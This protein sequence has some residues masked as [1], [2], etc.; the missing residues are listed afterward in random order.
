MK[1]NNSYLDLAT[2]NMTSDKA[3]DILNKEGIVNAKGMKLKALTS[4][5]SLAFHMVKDFMAGNYDT[6]WRNILPLAGALAY[7]ISPLDLVPD[8]IPI[9]GLSD[10]AAVL[11]AAFHYLAEEMAKYQIWKNK[12]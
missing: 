4:S 6:A 2:N 8:V 1:D 5:I 9:L 3:A 7:L 11:V 12:E 10:D